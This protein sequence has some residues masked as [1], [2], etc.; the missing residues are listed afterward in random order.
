MS[1][2][3]VEVNDQKVD[4]VKAALGTRTLKDTID[5]AFDTILAGVARQ[6]LIARL[7]RMD[8]LQLDDPAV[9]ERAWR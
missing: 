7:R 9:M 2:T 5:R 6:R 3:T 4:Q 8:G 1:K